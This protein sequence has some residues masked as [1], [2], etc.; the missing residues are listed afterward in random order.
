M[1][2]RVNSQ[3]YASDN[4]YASSANFARDNATTR[5]VKATDL[6]LSND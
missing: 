4:L 1:E 5:A 3:T 2:T 6:L